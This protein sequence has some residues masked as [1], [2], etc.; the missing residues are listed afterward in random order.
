MY[1][2][3][4]LLYVLISA[5]F[6]NMFTYSCVSI[7]LFVI[8][9]FIYVF[10]HFF[11]FVCMYLHAYSI[12]TCTHIHI[13]IYIYIY[14]YLCVLCVCLCLVTILPRLIIVLVRKKQVLEGDNIHEDCEGDLSHL[15]YN[16]I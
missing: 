1:I 14:T 8:Y 7:Y 10:I 11:L 16:W 4:L 9:L 3:T 13:Y 12:H 5:I 2:H 15:Y 6:L